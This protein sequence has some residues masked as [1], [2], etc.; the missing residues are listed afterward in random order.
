LAFLSTNRVG[1]RNKYIRFAT[2]AFNW[3]SSYNTSCVII[4]ESYSGISSITSIPAKKIYLLETLKNRTNFNGALKNKTLVI[5][6][7]LLGKHCVQQVTKSQAEI[8]V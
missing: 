4:L 8:R 3:A 7:Y 5:K 6:D 2:I 1:W